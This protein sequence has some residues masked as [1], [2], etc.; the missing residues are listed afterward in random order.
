MGHIEYYMM[1]TNQPY[2]F[3]DGANSG[4]HEAVG[5]TI[6]LSVSTPR[7]LQ[8][9]LGLQVGTPIACDKANDS[10]AITPEDINYLYF[11]ALDKV[12]MELL[13]L[14]R[15]DFLHCDAVTVWFYSSLYIP[16]LCPWTL[17]DGESLTAPF[18]SQNTTSNGGTFA[19][20]IKGS[21][22]QT[23]GMKR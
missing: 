21:Y 18:P 2:I 20:R 14:K 6:A 10:V 4:F 22:P 1:Y 16:S 19:E 23:R 11:L 5:D 3:R 15:M 9:K 7:H 17:G 8:C 13:V 12:L